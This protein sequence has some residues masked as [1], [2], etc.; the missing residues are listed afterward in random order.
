MQSSD[1]PEHFPLDCVI[2]TTRRKHVSLS[3]E[4]CTAALVL[5]SHSTNSL[6]DDQLFPAVGTG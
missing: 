5:Y 2:S 1:D 6:G 3:Q 4:M